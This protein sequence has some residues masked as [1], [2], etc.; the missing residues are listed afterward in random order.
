M[1]VKRTIKALLLSVAFLGSACT[2]GPIAIEGKIAEPSQVV[3]TYGGEWS[4]I[5]RRLYEYSHNDDVLCLALNAYH[6]GRNSSMYDQI[7]I[8]H[9]VLNRSAQVA[10]RP[11]EIVWA[12]RQFSWTHDGKSDMPYEFEAWTRALHVAES[13]VDGFAIDVTQGANHYHATY[14]KPYWSKAGYDKIEIGKHVFM[15]L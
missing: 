13:T 6:E 15:K 8:T 3:S 14:V 7:A 10:K 9:V 1:N 12:K 2:A 4:S 5:N 11:C